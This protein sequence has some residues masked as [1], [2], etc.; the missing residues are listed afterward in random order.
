[1]DSDRWK[2][3]DSLLQSVLERPPEER[4]AFLRHACAGDEALEREVRSL[5]RSQQQAGSFL[6]SPAI[7]VAARAL[8]GQQ[9]KDM[10]ESGDFPIGA[11]FSHYRIAGKLGG[12]G[13]GVVYKAEDTRLQRF[14]ALKYL[15]DELARDPEA[16]NRFRREARAASALNHWNICTIHDIG[17]QDGQAF[18]VMEYL[19]GATLKQRI[20]GDRFEM[21][22]LLAI[23]VEI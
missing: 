20:A 6:E 4:D 22:M 7:E 10:Q 3:V 15:S 18:L 23:G 1:M 19:E 11:T 14:V 13:M 2:Q 12:G 8:S 21:K 16:L 5:L 9:S 17:E